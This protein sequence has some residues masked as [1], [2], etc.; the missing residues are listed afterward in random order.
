ME[1]AGPEVVQPD[2]FPSETGSKGKTKHGQE[3][4]QDPGSGTELK[5]VC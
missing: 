1:L 3:R 4:G 5:T 2:T